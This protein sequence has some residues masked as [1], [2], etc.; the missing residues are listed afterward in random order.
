MSLIRVSE[1]AAKHNFTRQNAYQIIKRHNI[2]LSEHTH[3]ID[4]ELADR[5][6]AEAQ[7]PAKRRGGA[8]GGE[9]AQNNLAFEEE[10]LPVPAVPGG[11]PLGRAQLAD[12]LLR[13]RHRKLTVDQME[14]KLV[15]LASVR[16]FE[17]AVWAEASRQ[18]RVVGVELKD[19]LFSAE[20]PNEIQQM[21]DN[22]I[23]RILRSMSGW[24]PEAD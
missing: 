14:G 13:V 10:D 15:P 2:P 17:A 8:A 4:E 22:R 12:L 7:N 18:F 16:A 20:N 5:I 19:D 3:K 21:L 23:D 11:S 6:W 24:R 9:A 1:W